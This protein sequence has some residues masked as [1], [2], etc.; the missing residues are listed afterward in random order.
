MGRWRAICG[1]W[2]WARWSGWGRLFGGGLL[3][4]R[5]SAQARSRTEAVGEQLS[6]HGNGVAP[7][8]GRGRDELR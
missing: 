7:R 5:R 2:S 3:L 8:G 6:F 4:G 1:L